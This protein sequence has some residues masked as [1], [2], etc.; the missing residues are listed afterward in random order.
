M[1]Y[2][3]HASQYGTAMYHAHFSLQYSMGVYGP[4]I[5]NGPATAEYD[6]DLGP[7]FLSDWDHHTAFE[8]WATIATFNVT[9]N[10]LPTGLING[11]NTGNC[12]LTN[13][14]AP[15]PNC[16]DGGKKA[17]FVFE[18]GKK[19]RMRLI[20]IA[21]EGWFQ[22]SI[23]GHRLTVISADLVPIVPYET[24]S[25][26]VNMG[27]R[28]DVIVEANAPPGDYWL[29]SGFVTECIPNGLS[30]NINAIVRYNKDSTETP[31]TVSSVVPISNCLDEPADRV[32]P[33]MQVD[34]TNMYGGI[35]RQ[36]V[37]GTYYLNKYLRWSINQPQAG[38]IWTNWSQPAL[39]D[40]LSGNVAGIPDSNNVFVV[41]VS[42]LY[43]IRVKCGDRC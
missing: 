18:P 25:V 2:N 41:E 30:E 43:S 10:G 8:H 38:F 33:W 5:I 9:F 13:T 40:V 39:G 34:V 29:R 37:T 42:L 21:T 26:L 28:Y 16:I 14:T 15:D 22:F 24:D 23:D 7:V 36:N 1:T 6:E 11:M 35:E 20:N 32:V 19:Y 4:L 27:Q 3:F 17:E 12:T 31:I